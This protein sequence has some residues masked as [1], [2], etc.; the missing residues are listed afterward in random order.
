MAISTINTRIAFTTSI[1]AGRVNDLHMRV[2][3]VAKKRVDQEI[4]ASTVFPQTSDFLIW[5]PIHSMSQ[6]HV[7]PDRL[8]IRPH[9]VLTSVP[10]AALEILDDAAAEIEYFF[11]AVRV[12]Y[13]DG[14]SRSFSAL[15][16][17]LGFAL[18]SSGCGT[19]NDSVRRGACTRLESIDNSSMIQHTYRGCGY[20]QQQQLCNGPSQ[21]RHLCASPRSENTMINQQIIITSFLVSLFALRCRWSKRSRSLAQRQQGEQDHSQLGSLY[22]RR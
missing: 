22:Y 4:A 9:D 7:F 2:R 10:V 11:L 8:A 19:P 15:A 13:D 6:F 16:S 18:V 21:G 5:I 20:Q 14:Y 12:D 3:N 1:N 17:S